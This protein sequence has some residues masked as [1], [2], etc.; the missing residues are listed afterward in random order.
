MMIIDYLKKLIEI[1]NNLFLF[2]FSVFSIICGFR[3]TNIRF[4]LIIFLLHHIS[5]LNAMWKSRLSFET[6]CIDMTI[7]L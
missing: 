3:S 6:L 4:L 2:L 7:F 5:F 1:D